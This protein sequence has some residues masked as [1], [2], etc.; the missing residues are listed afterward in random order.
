MDRLTGHPET[1]SDL[2]PRPPLH[3]GSCHLLGFDTFCQPAK[4]QHG[5]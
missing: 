5:T 1:V 2:L 4:S 3:P